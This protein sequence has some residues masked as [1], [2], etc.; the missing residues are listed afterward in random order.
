MA[1]V[2]CIIGVGECDCGVR[3][4]ASC[5]ACNMGVGRACVRVGAIVNQLQSSDPLLTH[6]DICSLA[7]MV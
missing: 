3:P 4:S 2:D 1:D 6:W 5:V 7:I